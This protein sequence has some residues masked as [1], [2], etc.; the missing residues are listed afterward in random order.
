M[1]IIHL[2]IKHKNSI[3]FDEGTPID[4]NVTIEDF[5]TAFAIDT[6]GTRYNPSA[7]YAKNVLL[8]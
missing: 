7:Q 2:I 4:E 5:F 6:Q 3:L 8:N 1:P